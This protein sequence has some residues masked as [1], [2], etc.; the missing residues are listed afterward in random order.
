M[1]EFEDY[2][3]DET[4]DDG[5][6]SSTLV[7]VQGPSGAVFQVLTESERDWWEKVVDK[8][9]D[10]NKFTNV[11]DLQDLDRVIY[12]ELIMYRY[13]LWVGTGSDYDG[14]DINEVELNRN[15]QQYNKEVIALKKSIGIDKVSRD[16]DK[17]DSIAAYI[18]N[19]RRRA[20]EFGVKRNDEA[21]K[22]ITL[23]HKLKSMIELYDN[24]DDQERKQNHWTEA[25]MLKWIRESA[26]PDFE[27]IDEE[28]R[29]TS[30]TY[31]IRET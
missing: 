31:W 18:E 17:G 14:S 1:D 13:N 11:S 3:D 24:C 8:Y 19:L 6:I 9:L 4:L 2:Y 5:T 30:Q 15:I 7:E 12:M 16:K 27:K 29:K 21:V 20:K 10:H 26:I 25:D 28:F 22:A 23:F